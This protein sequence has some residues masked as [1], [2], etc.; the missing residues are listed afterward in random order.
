MRR[1]DTHIKI[2]REI[3]RERETK[4]HCMYREK[5]TYSYISIE[6]E[7]EEEKLSNLP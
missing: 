6:R 2:D 4:I 1:R 7:K 5:Q 3:D